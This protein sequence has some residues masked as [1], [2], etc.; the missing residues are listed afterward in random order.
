MVAPQTVGFQKTVVD[1]LLRPQPGLHGLFEGGVGSHVI[2]LLLESDGN[3]IT[4]TGGMVN[5]PKTAGI[6][7]TAFPFFNPFH[8][9]AV[10][11]G[12]GLVDRSL[13]LFFEAAAAPDNPRITRRS[14]A[15]PVRCR[16]R[17]GSASKC[18]LCGLVFQWGTRPP[19]CRTA[20]LRYL[21][22]CACRYN[23]G[24]RSFCTFRILRRG[25]WPHANCRSRSGMSNKPVLFGFFP[26][27]A[28]SGSRTCARSG[29]PLLLRC[30][31][32]P[33]VRSR[34]CLL[35]P[36]AA[37]GC[38]PELLSH[39]RTG[40]ARQYTDLP[41]DRCFLSPLIGRIADRLI[42]YVLALS[43][44]APVGGWLLAKKSFHEKTGCPIF[45]FLRCQ[46][47]GPLKN[48]ILIM[49]YLKRTNFY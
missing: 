22:G 11:K 33:W 25:Q 18:S 32:S 21:F 12:K 41:L 24:S 2:P 8:T 29:S 1:S 40:I 30:G 34:S 17:S 23:A 20:G 42:L 36:A 35:F 6:V 15:R 7:A 49:L 9:G 43:H 45:C 28:L 44:H 19:A 14:R 48:I 26:D 47:F 13:Q 46:T 10:N 37:F 16:S 5:S 31:R 38:W 39:S 4:S 27:K 3:P